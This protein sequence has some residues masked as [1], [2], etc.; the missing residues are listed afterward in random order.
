MK[1]T[2]FL[3]CILCAAGALGQ[4]AASGAL[5]AS[6]FQIVDHPSHASPQAL[7][8]EQNLAGFGTIS[9]AQ[10]EIPLSEVKLPEKHVTPLG[11]VARSFRKEREG[12]K[13]ATKI[14]EN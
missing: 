1:T 4:S 11:D 6:Q 9:I 10:G 2:V 3:M 12:E 13:K 14:F 8:P 5:L 7:T